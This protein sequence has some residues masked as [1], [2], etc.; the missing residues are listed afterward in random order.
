MDGAP[1]TNEVYTSSV[2]PHDRTL[3]S[4]INFV[5]G[6]NSANRDATSSNPPNGKRT[7]S[8]QS[9][10]VCLNSTTGGSTTTVISKS[11]MILGVDADNLQVDETTL[12][13]VEKVMF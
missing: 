12:T 4:N 10:M 8:A 1:T 5:N 3:Q 11:N 9:M 2:D 7:G 13:N 6:A